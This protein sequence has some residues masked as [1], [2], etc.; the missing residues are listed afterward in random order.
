MVDDDEESWER[1]P[2]DVNGFVE[3]GAA[4]T[5]R[6]NPH[7]RWEKNEVFVSVFESFSFH[8]LMSDLHEQTFNHILII[9]P[10]PITVK[11][12]QVND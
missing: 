2:A 6:P 3:D 8:F 9:Y 11:P 10:P 7:H 1:E 5:T 4:A 12:L